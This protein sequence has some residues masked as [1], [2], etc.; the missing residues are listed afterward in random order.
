MPTLTA[1]LSDPS[2]LVKHEELFVSE[3][4]AGAGDLSSHNK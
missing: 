1:C 4:P 2:E 3:A